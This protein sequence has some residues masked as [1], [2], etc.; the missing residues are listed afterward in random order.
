MVRE[1][2]ILCW[3][4]GVLE[5]SSRGPLSEAYS[6]GMYNYRPLYSLRSFTLRCVLKNVEFSYSSSTSSICASLV[7][8]GQNFIRIVFENSN[9]IDPALFHPVAFT[10]NHIISCPIDVP[11]M[12]H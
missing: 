4:S 8:R 2:R 7:P 11:L 12:S 5:S 9:R 10:T 1:I 3:I 6:T